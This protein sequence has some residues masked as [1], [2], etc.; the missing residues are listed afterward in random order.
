MQMKKQNKNKTVKKA[1]SQRLKWHENYNKTF[2]QIYWY[3]H[4]KS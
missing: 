2:Y 4:Y 1:Y 3:Y